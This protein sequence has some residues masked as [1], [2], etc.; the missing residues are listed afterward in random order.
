MK[1]EH[2][3]ASYNGRDFTRKFAVTKVTTTKNYVF[4]FC[5]MLFSYLFFQLNA[6]KMVREFSFILKV[7]E[8]TAN[9]Q[10]I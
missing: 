6:P 10:L 8:K 2:T 3:V 7:I 9:R 1:A 4:S 5:E